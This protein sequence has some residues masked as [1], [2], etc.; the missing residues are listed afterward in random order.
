MLRW[1][2]LIGFATLLGLLGCT[3]LDQLTTQTDQP[4]DSPDLVQALINENAD[5]HWVYLPKEDAW[6]AEGPRP[7]FAV[8]HRGNVMREL[9]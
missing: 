6:I 9:K 1:F 8:E 4:K 3:P 5:L 2:K 7:I